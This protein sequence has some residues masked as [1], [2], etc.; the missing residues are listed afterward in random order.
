[1]LGR[2]FGRTKDDHDDTVCS[3][4]GRTLLAGE[5]T[6]RVV[7]NDGTERFICSLCARPDGAVDGPIEPAEELATGAGGR[8]KPTRADTDVFWRALKDKDAEIERL[9][10]LLAR[11]EAE[12][13]ELAA[14]LAQARGESSLDRSPEIG[15]DTAEMAAPAFEAEAD[16]YAAADQA[17]GD[18]ATPAPVAGAAL[19][20]PL[21]HTD[22]RLGEALR[23]A[24]EPAAAADPADGA[25]AVDDAAAL[26]AAA[27]LDA[28][29]AGPAPAPSPFDG[30]AGALAAAAFGSDTTV[31]GASAPFNPEPVATP[32]AAE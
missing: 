12:K 19:G 10:S 30:E 20:A 4:C 16:E 8:V 25:T 13:Q 7:D 9:E 29:D 21:E 32:I 1:M 2:L 5:W 14:Q 6:Q 18:T 27:A 28:S 24:A 26:G 15:A 17:D 23:R 22:P 3:N 11:S 31:D